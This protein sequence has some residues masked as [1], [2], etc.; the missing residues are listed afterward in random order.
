MGRVCRPSGNPVIHLEL[1]T[2]DL[3][4]TVAFYAGLCGWRPRRIHSGSCS[5]LSL[6]MGDGVGG[7]VVEC[8][9]ERSLW[10]PYEDGWLPE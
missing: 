9:A 10:V 4:G 8:K 2:S 6:E 5:Y 1:H 3:S 7:G